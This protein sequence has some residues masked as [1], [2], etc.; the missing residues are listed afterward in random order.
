MMKNNNSLKKKRML[1]KIKLITLGLL[2]SAAVIGILFWIFV[3]LGMHL[4]DIASNI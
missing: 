4:G 3:S 1:R 2:I